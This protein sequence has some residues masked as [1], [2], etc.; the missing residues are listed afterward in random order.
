MTCCIY[1]YLVDQ[2]EMK[3][4]KMKRGQEPRKKVIL[5][6]K[7]KNIYSYFC[8][9][10]KVRC[11]KI[12][13]TNQNIYFFF[14]YISVKFFKSS[15]LRIIMFSSL[16]FLHLEMSTDLKL[17]RLHSEIKISLKIDNPVS[18]H[19]SNLTCYSVHISLLTTL[20]IIVLLHWA[21]EDKR[22]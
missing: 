3:R 2:V 5:A 8:G 20:W 1:C 9:K 16:F 22:C 21:D 12:L 6:V 18:S 10:L 19:H 14:I 4:R 7:T 11:K 15:Y 17:Q 13:V